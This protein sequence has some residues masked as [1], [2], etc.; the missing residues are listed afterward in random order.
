M[1]GFRKKNDNSTV[2]LGQALTTVVAV[3]ALFFGI[4]AARWSWF[5]VEELIL[6]RQDFNELKNGQEQLKIQFD[7]WDQKVSEERANLRRQMNANNAA[8]TPQ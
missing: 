7:Y 3:V 1:F 6:L 4:G 2:T 8:P 5:A